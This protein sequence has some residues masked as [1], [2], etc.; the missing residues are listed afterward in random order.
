M[1]MIP[2][3]T[4]IFVFRP[5]IGICHQ[6]TEPLQGRVISDLHEYVIY[7]G[8]QRGEM[9]EPLIRSPSTSIHLPPTLIP[10]HFGL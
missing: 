5:S 10:L 8:V 3:E 6:F 9:V 1:T 4:A 7:R 2:V